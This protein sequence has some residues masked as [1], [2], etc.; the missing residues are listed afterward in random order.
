MI[1]HVDTINRTFETRLLFIQDVFSN[2]YD[3]SQI[4]TSSINH[5]LKCSFETYLNEVEKSKAVLEEKKPLTV[6]KRI[7]KKEAKK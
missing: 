2:I 6:L 1:E 3:K 5:K 4:I 7:N